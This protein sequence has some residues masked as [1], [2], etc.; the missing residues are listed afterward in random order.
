MRKLKEAF[1]ILLVAIGINAHAQ[2]LPQFS[3]Y[4]FT[5]L[6][7]N[8]AYCGS[9]DG[10]NIETAFRAQ[11]VGLPERPLTQSIGAHLPMP[12]IN[13]GAGVVVIND[14]LGL[15][16]K[17]AIYANYAYARQIGKRNILAAGIQVG[18]LQ[19]GW[20]G[21]RFISPEGEYGGGIINHNDNLIP[22]GTQASAAVNMNV[23]LLYRAGNLTTGLAVMNL[24][25]PENNFTWADNRVS[26]TNT[27]HYLL[28][29]AYNFEI[30]RII[31]LLPSV[32]MKTD[33]VK[34]QIDAGAILTYDQMFHGG[35]SIRGYEPSSFD[36]V[37]IIGGISLGNKWLISYAYDIGIS[38]LRKFN[39]GSHELVVHYR[40]SNFVSQNKGKTIYNPRFM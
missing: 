10:I 32:L 30:N 25:E 5:G 1:L 34:Y 17:T 38:K 9:R 39:A 18:M 36:A 33:M 4:G 22:T 27:R 26:V 2:Q 7:Y 28:N 21:N 3:Q 6:V 13:S 31:T 40:I 23:G 29:F 16:R 12:V 11:W 19:A 15:E 35:V 37:A 8:P 14:M 20:Q 24:L